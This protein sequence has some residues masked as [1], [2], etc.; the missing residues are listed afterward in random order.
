MAASKARLAVEI[1]GKRLP[2]DEARVVWQR[3]SEFMD[4]QNGDFAAFAIDEG[5]KSVTTRTTNG[6]AVLIV[7]S[8]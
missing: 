4:A 7:T 6:Q 5:V 1:D 3:F 8:K 2:D